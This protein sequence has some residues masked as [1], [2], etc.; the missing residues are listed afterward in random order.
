MGL[1]RAGLTEVLVVELDDLGVLMRLADGVGLVQAVQDLGALGADVHEVADRGMNL[2]LTAAV[3]TAAGAG[4]ELDE[5]V[6]LLAGLDHIQ[7]LADICQAGG[8]ADVHIHTGNVVGGFLDAFDT[9]D[10]H[11]VGT[12]Q[13][14][15]GEPFHSGT[16]SSFHNAAGGT[17]DDSRAGAFAQ[18]M[19][20]VFLRQIVPA[21][22]G[23]LDHAGQLTGGHGVVHVGQAGTG[24]IVTADLELL[25]GAGHNGDG[26]NVLRVDAHLLG[27]VALGDGALHLL[28]RLA[29][30]HVVGELGIVVLTELDPAG[31]AGGDHRQLAAVL[32][33]IQELVG[34]FHD[35]QVSTEVGIEDLVEAETAQRS[36][37]LALGIGADGLAE[38][39]RQSGTD[40]GSGLHDHILVGIGNGLGHVVDAGFLIQSAHGADS[41]TL[42]AADAGGVGQVHLEGG[43]DVGLEAAVV[44]ADNADALILLTGSNTATA[45]DALGVVADHV[46]SGLVD[47]GG[48]LVAGVEVLVLDTVLTAQSLQLAVAGTDAGQAG[49]VMIG[50]QQLQGLL[51]V[52]NDLGRVGE[53]FGVVPING[54]HTGSAEA[55]GALDFNDADTAGADR[56]DVLEVAEGGD[57]DAGHS[58]CFQNGST[59]GNGHF[60][61][62]D[63]NM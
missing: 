41:D 30:R 1:V 23:A 62:V 53:N 6:V 34:F 36:S 61:A 46:G 52:G 38:F 43:A 29:G 12:G 5:V 48:V 27:E 2:G 56:I 7:D 18:R 31:R 11:E 10:V 57:G 26:D 19:I 58:G 63:F 60:N 3:D 35:G 28:R 55:A 39:F 4:H 47:L 8:H 24:L 21:D 51:P 44:G 13:S 17:E 42:T 54:I 32:H 25:R 9:A 16:Q 14:L 40:S 22:A 33:T 37:H 20:K 59:L 50:E 49:A 15:A 45:Q